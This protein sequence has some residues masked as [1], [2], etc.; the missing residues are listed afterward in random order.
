MATRC[1]VCG[2]PQLQKRSG[3]FHFNVPDNIPGGLI[4]VPGAVWEECS[5]CGEKILSKDLERSID[6]QTYERLGLLAPLRIREIR[7]R[8]CLNQV[9][10]AQLLGVGDR[11]YANWESGR[12]M[13][14]KSSDNLLR[15]VEKQPELFVRLEAQRN[16]ARRELIADYVKGLR[17]AD[18]NA[19]TR[20]AAHGGVMDS[21]VA[22]ALREAIKRV[23]ADEDDA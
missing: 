13:H 4:V 19:E 23:A 6:E 11:T 8:A 16:P 10:M 17:E 15:L 1:P 14:H 20:L 21:R 12:S 3:N 22:T 5:A 18:P 9:E 7:E 2:E